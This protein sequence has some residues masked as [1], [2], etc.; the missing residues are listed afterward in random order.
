M[1]LPNAL[2]LDSYSG[3][4]VLAVI[5]NAAVV[6]HCEEGATWS[7]ERDDAA[8][9]A[10]VHLNGKPF[11]TYSYRDDKISR[12]YFANVLAPG[13][14]KI[15]RNHPPSPDD[16]QDHE[17]MHPGM[18]LAFGDISGQDYWRLKAPVEHVRF[19]AEPKASGDTLEFG[20]ENRYM[21]AD[22]NSEVCRET[23]TYSLIKKPGGVL[24]LWDSKFRSDR[25]R[26]VFGDQ[27][28]MGL[29]VR[30]AKPVA[31]KSNSG[32]RILNSN[33]QR[34]EDEAWGKQA[35]WF[36]Y[37]GTVDGQFVG[38]MVMPHP[39]NFRRSW[40]HVRDTGFMA[41]NPFGQNA[42]TDGEKSAIAVPRGE[43]F[44]LRY[45]VLFHWNDRP[46]E[47]DPERAY[48]ACLK[49]IEK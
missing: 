2:R 31:V 35:D 7:L 21:S 24:M 9:A 48:Q 18:W 5:L 29:G 43:T 26:F 32:G 16:P 15:T 30:L 42:F 1:K 17:L 8:G 37:S 38:I 12:P 23:C 3:L 47:F 22:G 19:V 45:A 34:N 44:R 40:G 46:E 41:A 27:E 14:V 10:I 13:G 20:V 25:D 36:D 6:A 33:G 49:H 4:V 28:E 39:K 11:I